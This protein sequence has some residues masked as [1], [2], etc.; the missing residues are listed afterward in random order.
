MRATLTKRRIFIIEVESA[1]WRAVSPSTGSGQALREPQGRRVQ[2]RGPGGLPF[3]SLRAGA[4]GEDVA[5]IER[6]VEARG[7]RFEGAAH[8]LTTLT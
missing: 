4:F 6:G 5:L 2:E 3:E 8:E 1:R 7:V